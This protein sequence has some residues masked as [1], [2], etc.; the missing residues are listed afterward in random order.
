MGDNFDFKFILLESYTKLNN[1]TYLSS[2]LPY[3]ILL[4]TSLILIIDFSR[5]LLNITLVFLI[6]SIIVTKKIKINGKQK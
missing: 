2:Y 4:H 6:K 1:N 5:F 3:Y